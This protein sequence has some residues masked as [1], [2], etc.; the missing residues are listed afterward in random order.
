MTKRTGKTQSKAKGPTA[1]P[2]APAEPKPMQSPAP[3][4]AE[5]TPIQRPA[6]PEEQ[7]QVQLAQQRARAELAVLKQRFADTDV[8]MTIAQAERDQVLQQNQLLRQE[9]EQL[10]NQIA[11]LTNDEQVKD[12]NPSTESDDEQTAPADSEPEN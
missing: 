2:Q 10:K 7:V 4:P 3:A 11:A 12:D 9:N 8:A 5:P 1:A 6:T